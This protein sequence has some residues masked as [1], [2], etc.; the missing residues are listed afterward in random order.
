MAVLM[1]LATETS[2]P[3]RSEIYPD[4]VDDLRG[5]EQGAIDVYCCTLVRRL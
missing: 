5:L 1:A 4:D 3:R 2:G